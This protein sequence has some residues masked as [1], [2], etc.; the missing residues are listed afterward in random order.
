MTHRLTPTLSWLQQY[1]GRT[2]KK[3]SKL[4]KRILR[5]FHF[6]TSEQKAN[7][8]KK[9]AITKEDDLCGKLVAM[10]VSVLCWLFIR[11]VL[12]ENDTSSGR[13]S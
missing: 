6:E 7:D 2:E 8:N 10:K 5:I 4:K 9:A 13:F 1:D 12:V 3:A 11:V